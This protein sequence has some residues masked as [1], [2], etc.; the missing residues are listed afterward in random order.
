MRIMLAPM[1]G[2][3]DFHMRRIL[4]AIGGYNRCVTEFLRVTDH[5]YP[6]RVFMR[7][8]PELA[9]EGCTTTGTPVY[10]QLLGSNPTAL[11][12]NARRAVALG[13]PGIDLNF[14]CPAKTVNRHGG[15]SSLLRTPAII[16]EI[17]TAVR[18]AVDSEIPVTV[19]I[20]L[21]FDDSSL[22]LHTA[23]LIEQAGAT[24]LC[25]HARTRSDGYKPP[26]HWHEVEAVRN[27]LNIPVIINGE[28]WNARCSASAQQDSGCY[29]VMLGRG[30]LSCPDLAV[31]LK[32]A[33]MNCSIAELQWSDIV[34]LL[35]QLLETA[36]HLPE[37]YAGNRTKQW[38]TY[39]RRQ[40]AGADDLFNRVKRLRKFEDMVREISL[41]E[42]GLKVGQSGIA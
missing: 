37:K 11:A 3:T 33:E 10:L 19:K 22:L 34:A 41:H 2:V 30:A 36:E 29:D 42:K 15:G 17:V 18:Q 5:L 28:I 12:D 14:G 6:E 25:V 40:Y 1:E 16:Q 24:E 23:C 31:Q 13:A 35:Q 9:N 8:C 4:T 27:A 7:C 38:L 21:G 20:R 26:A 32:S 39:L